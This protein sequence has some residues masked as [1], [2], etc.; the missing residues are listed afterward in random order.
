LKFEHLDFV[1]VSDF[2]IRISD[3]LVLSKRHSCLSPNLF[4]WKN[5]NSNLLINLWDSENWKSFKMHKTD[6]PDKFPGIEMFDAFPV[7]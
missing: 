3:L 6:L 4:T 1:F 7:S 2:D 5:R